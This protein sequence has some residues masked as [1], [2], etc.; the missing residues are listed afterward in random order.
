MIKAEVVGDSINEFGNRI[1]TMEVT[2]PRIVLAE[3]NT[4]RMF[5]RNSASSRA[6]PFE[7][8]S[9]TIEENP[10]V[11]IAWQINHK[12]M[13]GSEYITEPR[14]VDNLK[15]I[16]LNGRDAA[17]VYAT[18]LHYQ[19][20][21]KQL[22]NRGLETY[23]WHKVLVTATE[24]EN[25]FA[26]RCPQYV[27]GSFGA[28]SIKDIVGMMHRAAEM[29]MRIDSEGLSTEDIVK[30]SVVDKLKHNKGQAEIH[31]MAVAEAMW[32]AYNESKPEELKEGEWHIPYKNRIDFGELGIATA[33][34]IIEKGISG[35]IGDVNNWSSRVATV[36]AARVSYTVVGEDQ[37]PLSYKRMFEIYDDLLNA[38]PKHMS[39]F[40]HCGK[41]MSKEEHRSYIYT[42]G[43]P[44]AIKDN[45]TDIYSIEGW[46]GNFRGFIQLRKT[47]QGENIT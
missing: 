29:D 7:K 32:D 9:R 35:H 5:S 47:I 37:K 30:S 39:P 23:M 2:M 28:R 18:G 44:L 41:A 45:K 34:Y 15:Q 43:N 1:T 22:C 17:I 21:T 3:F 42:G 36:M 10:F 13:Q 19:N 25:F 24:F 40:E 33:E 38:N 27:Y 4:H 26:L 11:P 14:E 16:W 20:V 6:I 8:M 31:M 12:G 46:C